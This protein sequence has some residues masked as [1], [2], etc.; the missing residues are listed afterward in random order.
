MDRMRAMG[1]SSAH[2]KPHLSMTNI[3][4]SRAEPIKLFLTRVA[5]VY[6]EDT[7][8]S[9]QQTRL[10]GDKSLPEIRPIGDISMS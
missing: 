9:K 3:A 4:L 8:Y 7:P 5:P 2:D 1:K 10:I 6:D